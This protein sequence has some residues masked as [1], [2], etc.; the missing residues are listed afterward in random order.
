M[1]LALC[2]QTAAMAQDNA[3]AGG[4]RGEKA[5]VPDSI[6]QQ[7]INT[8]SFDMMVYHSTDVSAKVNDMYNQVSLALET[9][10]RGFWEKEGNEALDAVGGIVSTNVLSLVL[11]GVNAIGN[12]FKD[13]KDKKAEE[14][15]TWQ[16]LVQKENTYEET[17]AVLQNLGDFY[18]NISTAG[19]LDPTSIKFSGIS[20][21]QRRGEDTVLYIS[22]KL[23][24]AATALSR[25]VCHSKFQLMLD[26]LIFKPSMCD[27]PNDTT[28]KFSEKTKFSFEEKS[29]LCV[30]FDLAVTSSWINQAIQVHDDVKLG[31]FSVSVP[32][33]EDKISKDDGMFRYYAADVPA[34][35]R[36]SVS[37]DS[38]IVPRSYIGIRDSSGTYHDA[39]GTGQY[40]LALTIKETCDNNKQ[41]EED[42]WEDD[43]KKRNGESK[44]SSSFNL[45]KWAT[46][47]WNANKQQWVVTILE[48]PAQEATEDFFNWAKIYYESEEASSGAMP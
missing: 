15:Q 18:G 22:Y 28:K 2:C 19:A 21:L 8:P 26:T 48:A 29:D 6:K 4:G 24:T 23:D 25:I 5:Q 38:F 45:I 1:A 41:W 43:Y 13:K 7:M 11:S 14:K 30:S 12:L 44:K 17:I 10:D 47:Y 27:L 31:S 32:I 46:Q 39:W 16:Q 34:E 3:P 9:G 35:N 20:C 33:K 36:Y 37:G 40:K 42:N